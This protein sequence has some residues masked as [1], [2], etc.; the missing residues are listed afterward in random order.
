M[1]QQKA[2]SRHIFQEKKLYDLRPLLT[3]KNPYTTLK[4]HLVTRGPLLRLAY[5]VGSS[6]LICCL[7]ALTPQRNF[8]FTPMGA[9]TVQAYAIHCFL[10]KAYGS[11][12]SR[13]I[14]RPLGM[15]SIWLLV[16]LIPLSL[17]ITLICSP[18]IFEKP[19]NF[20]LSP[21]TNSRTNGDR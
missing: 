19:F 2:I 17:V 20:L 4:D 9:R 16:I 18:K 1:K 3:G 11:L 10:I 5:Y 12:I 21:G 7:V 13:H 15:G 6:V 8:P 14:T